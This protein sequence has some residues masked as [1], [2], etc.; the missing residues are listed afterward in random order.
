MVEERRAAMAPPAQ[1]RPRRTTP[2]KRSAWY[3]YSGWI[4]LSPTSTCCSSGTRLRVFGSKADSSNEFTVPG[5]DYLSLQK[6]AGARPEKGEPPWHCHALLAARG[7]QP[8]GT[9]KGGHDGE[10]R[11]RGI[12]YQTALERRAD[13]RPVWELLDP[14]GGKLSMP[15]ILSM[16]WVASAGRR[17]PYAVR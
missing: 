16:G 15:S 2:P 11:P 4:P 5:P 8:L 1:A 10:S 17:N 7:D 3:P 9:G 13:A 6:K 14:L 12:R